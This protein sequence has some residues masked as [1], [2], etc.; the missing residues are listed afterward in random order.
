[1]SDV[2]ENARHMARLLKRAGEPRPGPGFRRLRELNLGWSHL[3]AL[4]SLA[5]DHT[6]SM[7]ELAEELQLTPPSVTMLA[8]RLVETGL[9]RRAPHPGDSRVALLALTER[10][11]SLYEQVSQEHVARMARLLGG[12]T[13]DEQQQF[14]SLLERA[15]EALRQADEPVD[16]PQ[17]E[18]VITRT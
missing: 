15:V 13:P 9:L 5:P 8:R 11:R 14:L 2:V 12:L 1:M 10:G 17:P 18:P 6:L 4:E 16:T 3:R 7:K